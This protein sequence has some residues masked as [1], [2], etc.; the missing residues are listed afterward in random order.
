MYNKGVN[1]TWYQPVSRLASV[2]KLSMMLSLSLIISACPSQA[3]SKPKQATIE[4]RKQ[5]IAYLEKLN[6]QDSFRFKESHAYPTFK[7]DNPYET[8]L[9]YHRSKNTLYYLTSKLSK[10]NV[11]EVHTKWDDNWK[12]VKITD[13]SRRYVSALLNTV[14]TDDLSSRLTDP[15]HLRHLTIE[16]SLYRR[17]RERVR[18]LKD[19]RALLQREKYWIEVHPY[20]S[21]ELTDRAVFK[22]NE[23]LKQK[24][25]PF[26]KALQD[27]HNCANR[28]RVEFSWSQ[29]Q[30][31]SCQYDNKTLTLHWQSDKKR[32]DAE[33]LKLL[34][35]AT[36]K[37]GIN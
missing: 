35:N 8:G 1:A 7:A 24:A 37:Q 14:L 26:I 30:G 16:E 21:V 32:T 22:N 13:G 4:E 19:V 34:D 29:G 25:I 6:P 15:K 33:L 28:M 11:F 3:M 9:K 31:E 5:V 20:F 10:D 2:F 36:V 17:V 18:T 12:T 27:T 23:Q